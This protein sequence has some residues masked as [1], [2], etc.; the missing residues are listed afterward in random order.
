MED[1]ANRLCDLARRVSRGDGAAAG[2]LL[3]ELE[4]RMTMIVRRVMRSQAPTSVLAARILSEA[5][6]LASA[7]QALA[8]GEK[9]ELIAQVAR[10]ICVSLV[11]R[12]RGAP[13]AWSTLCD[14]LRL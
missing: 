14:T 11:D 9:E 1:Q 12:L 8:Q 10:T 5:G 7:R 4:P 2:L 6:R 13:D 3:G